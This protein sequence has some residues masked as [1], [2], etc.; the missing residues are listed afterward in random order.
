MI[1]LLFHGETITSF[2]DDQPMHCFIHKIKL[3]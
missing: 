1:D 2:E 3:V